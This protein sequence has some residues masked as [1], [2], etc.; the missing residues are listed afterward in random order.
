MFPSNSSCEFIYC[1]CSDIQLHILILQ[2]SSTT[3]EE[4]LNLVQKEQQTEDN[5]NKPRYDLKYKSHIM[6]KYLQRLKQADS[7]EETEEQPKPELCKWLVSAANFT[8]SKNNYIE[9]NSRYNL[10]LS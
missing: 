6:E 10:L 3:D 7:I 5:N 2:I 9:W 1:Y 8:P 4:A